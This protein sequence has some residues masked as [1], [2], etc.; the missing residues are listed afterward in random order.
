MKI[1]LVPTADLSFDG[2]RAR[3]TGWHPE[4]YLFEY[5]ILGMT[6]DCDE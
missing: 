4:R 2:D 1:W 3:L 5:K 6:C